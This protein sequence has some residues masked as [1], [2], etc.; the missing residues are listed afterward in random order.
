MPTILIAAGGTGGHLFPALAVADE[1]R[2]RDPQRRIVFAGTA[3]GLETRLVPRAGNEL[4]LLPILPL[5]AVGLARQA[6]GLVALPWGCLL[7]TSDAA[8][9]L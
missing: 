3:R 4:A 6:R 2:R 1:L 9:E 5:N 8:D 7:Y